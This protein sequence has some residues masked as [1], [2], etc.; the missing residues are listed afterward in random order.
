MTAA[1][2]AA[3]A[4]LIGLALAGGG[5]GKSTHRNPSDAELALERAQFAQLLDGLISAQPSVEREVAASRVAWPA[6]ASGLPSSFPS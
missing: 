2:L 1:G 4:V 3:V 6:I 5:C